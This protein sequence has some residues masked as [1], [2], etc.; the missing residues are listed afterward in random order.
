MGRKQFM[1]QNLGKVLILKY[2]F[3]INYCYYYSYCHYYYVWVDWLLKGSLKMSESICVT[4]FGLSYLLDNEEYWKWDEEG[5]DFFCSKNKGREFFFFSNL[6]SSWFFFFLVGSLFKR[7]T[8]WMWITELYSCVEV[9][10]LIDVCIMKILIY[11]LIHGG[12]SRLLHYW[13]LNSVLGFNHSSRVNPTKRG[14]AR[15]FSTPKNNKKKA[16]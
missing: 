13:L 5:R 2:Y 14:G 10:Y 3:I 7:L 1:Q 9:N 15:R 12:N 16:G 8:I 11:T 4:V 6:S